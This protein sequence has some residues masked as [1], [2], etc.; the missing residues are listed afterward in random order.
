MNGPFVRYSQGPLP[1][2]G[3]ET[4]VFGPERRPYVRLFGTG[5]ETRPLNG[6]GRGVV[7]VFNAIRSGLPGQIVG[8]QITQP[9]LPLQPL[10]P[11]TTG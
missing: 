6:Q 10:S 7:Q 9:L 1:N 4:L 3:Y 11:Y 2:P 8:E 5:I